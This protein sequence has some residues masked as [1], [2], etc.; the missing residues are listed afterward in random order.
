MQKNS[1]TLRVVCYIKRAGSKGTSP[2]L[3][4][5][6]AHQQN[7]WDRFRVLGKDKYLIRVKK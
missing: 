3:F 2:A 6:L 1:G 4:C 7:V 5:L